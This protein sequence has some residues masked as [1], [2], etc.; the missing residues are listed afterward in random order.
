ME[1]DPL[2]VR[3][4]KLGGVAAFLDAM[5]EL[6]ELEPPHF[7]RLCR[8]KR[9]HHDLRTLEACYYGRNLRAAAC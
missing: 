8:R 1:R 6:K 9:I 2:R 7:Y 5:G 4:L 3:R